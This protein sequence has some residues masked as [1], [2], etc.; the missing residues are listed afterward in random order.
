MFSE[1]PDDKIFEYQACGNNQYKSDGGDKECPGKHII[2]TRR[3]IIIVIRIKFKNIRWHSH[4]CESHHHG[5]N[6]H[7]NAGEPV[8]VFVKTTSFLDE[9]ISIQQTNNKASINNNRGNDALPAD[10][11]VIKIMN[12]EL[13]IVNVQ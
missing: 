8:L 3:Q 4:A 7:E 12:G 13:S 1:F 9:K 6:S 11:H 2:L 10:A 5:G